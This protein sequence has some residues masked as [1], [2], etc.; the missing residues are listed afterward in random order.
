MYKICHPEPLLAKDLRT[1][2]RSRTHVRGFSTKSSS[3]KSQL[4]AIQV[5]QIYRRSFAKSGS[6]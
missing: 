2:F 1:M 4:S 6:G 3:L 5:R